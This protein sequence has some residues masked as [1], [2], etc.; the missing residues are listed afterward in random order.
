M[1]LYV[2]GSTHTPTGVNVG[3]MSHAAPWTGINVY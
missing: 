2:L 3:S 1:D